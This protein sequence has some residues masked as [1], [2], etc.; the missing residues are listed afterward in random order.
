MDVNETA[1][2]LLFPPGFNRIENFVYPWINT[3]EEAAT[4]GSYSYPSRYSTEQPSTA[5]LPGGGVGGNPN[6]WDV[7]YHVKADIK[8]AGPYDG[9]YVL[10]L[11]VGLPQYG[12]TSSPE[13][14]LRGFDKVS[15]NV[16]ETTTVNFDLLRRDLSIWD[17]VSQSWVVPRGE[18]KVYVGSSSRTL[19]L[20]GTF[21]IE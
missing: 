1:A 6:L 19:E 3:T 16:G 20:Q 15:L 12:Q 18:Y 14:Q 5:P 21:T 13:R 10:Q 9:A 7:A 8:N 11:Y 17:V 2:D 4:N